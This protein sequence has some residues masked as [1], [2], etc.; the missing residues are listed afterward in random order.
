[1]TR[2]GLTSSSDDNSP[3]HAG[4]LAVQEAAGVRER[5]AQLGPMFRPAM[6][7]A[8]RAFFERLPFVLVGSLDGAGQPWASLLIGPP[9]FVRAPD[10]ETLLIFAQPAPED[11]LAGAIREGAA[12]GLLGIEL[13]ARRRARLNGHVHEVGAKGFSFHIDQSF[14]NCP[15]YITPRKRSAASAEQLPARTALPESNQLSAAA[16][17]CIAQA[18]TC[19]IASAS[20][21]NTPEGDRR[22]GVDV[23]HRGGE[24]GFVQI[25]SGG[26][27]T[28]L[29]MP[30]YP[31]NNAFNTL[32]NLV[33]YPR[34]GL[35]FPEF[36]SGDVLLVTCDAEI[37]F[38][39]GGGAASTRDPE[40]LARFAG[41]QRLVT[42]TVRSAVYFQR[43]MPFQWDR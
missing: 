13:E 41:A 42:F 33:R 17:A 10:P 31:G 18:D 39:D 21:A 34:A 38:G 37:V 35:L 32:G 14:G 12:L 30:D 3:F 22:E 24:R 26:G 25:L 19:F 36:E 11:P 7:D 15:K 43:F 8:Y 23:S 2:R 27:A 40:P 6:A 1:M 9:G 29:F 4:E 5:A 28:Q 20:A 16:L